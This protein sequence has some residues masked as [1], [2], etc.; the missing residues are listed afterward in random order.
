[1]STPLAWD[2]V[3]IEYVKTVMD[4][5]G[6]DTFFE[7]GTYQGQTSLYFANRDYK[8]ITV[9]ID[10]NTYLNNL[11]KFKGKNIKSFNMSSDVLLFFYASLAD[12]SKTFFYLDAHGHGYATPERQGPLKE[13]LECLFTLPKF[14]VLVHDA[15]KGI[16]SGLYRLAARNAAPECQRDFDRVVLPKDIEVISPI[17]DAEGPAYV[18]LNKGHKLVASKN[19]SFDKIR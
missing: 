1:M 15:Q 4:E 6:L 16:G 12:A 10:K 9:E 8:V 3:L 2:N 7:T 13:E 11:E 5:L 18:L 19:F 14:I 17:Y